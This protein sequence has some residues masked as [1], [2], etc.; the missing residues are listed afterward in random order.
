M[1]SLSLENFAAISARLDAGLPR[2]GVLREAGLGQAAWEA[3]L[4]TWLRNLAEQVQRQNYEL[5]HRYT[6][7]FLQYRLE[8]EKQLGL[9]SAPLTSAAAPALP[10]S[11]PEQPADW[12]Y[13]RW[14]AEPTPP[15]IVASSPSVTS[16][17]AVPPMPQVAAVPPMPQVAAVPPMPQAPEPPLFGDA[18]T[19]PPFV[20]GYGAPASAAAPPS[21]GDAPTSP[22]FVTPPPVVGAPSFGDAPTSPPFVTP[23]PVVGAPPLVT[24]PASG[25]HFA[26]SAP[27]L[28]T[29]PPSGVGAYFVAPEASAAP[30]SHPPGTS[31]AYVPDVSLGDYAMLRA[32]IA[33]APEQLERALAKYGIG[34]L[35]TWQAVQQA[36]GAK[37]GAGGA[38]LATYHERYESAVRHFR[39]MYSR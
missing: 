37:L 1:S 16:G 10:A 32:E 4:S 18:P 19:S 31:G 5:F 29:P 11:G 14:Q 2:D 33:V 24:P 12:Q 6:Q 7:W 22:P 38:N 39:T 36:W 3:E 15:P 30:A 26:A 8:A 9:Q 17:P 28:V 34:D 20:S 23:P 35:A 21:F 13:L 27:A 25:P